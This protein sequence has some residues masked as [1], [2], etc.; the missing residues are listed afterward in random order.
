MTD[1]E[2][3][4]EALSF[5]ENGPVFCSMVLELHFRWQQRYGSASFTSILPLLDPVK[6]PI[7]ASAAFSMPS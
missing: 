6:S 7:K 4:E 5:A 3:I 2:L 1:D